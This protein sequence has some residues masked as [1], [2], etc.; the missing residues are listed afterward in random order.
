M[1]IE[2]IMAIIGIILGA[3]SGIANGYVLVSTCRK[4]KQSFHN[5][6]NQSGKARDGAKNTADCTKHSQ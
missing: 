5:R 1:E 4:T 2:K 3:V 6:N